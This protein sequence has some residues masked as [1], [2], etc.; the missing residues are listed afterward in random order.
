MKVVEAERVPNGDISMCTWDESKD[1]LD[2]VS[3]FADNGHHFHIFATPVRRAADG[4]SFRSWAFGTRLGPK[5]VGTWSNRAE[6]ATQIPPALRIVNYRE[7]LMISEASNQAGLPCSINTGASRGWAVYFYQRGEAFFAQRQGDRSIL[8]ILE[9]YWSR[10]SDS[11]RNNTARRA[12]CRYSGCLF[13]RRMRSANR[14][15]AH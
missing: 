13:P 10:R 12:K 8:L 11:P 1:A 6:G 7:L 14:I 9:G 2:A 15:D 3:P 5:A 4:P